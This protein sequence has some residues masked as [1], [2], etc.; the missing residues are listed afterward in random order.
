MSTVLHSYYLILRSFSKCLRRITEPLWRL[1]FWAFQLGRCD[2]T[3]PLPPSP[4]AVKRK[5]TPPNEARN[6]HRPNLDGKIFLQLPN[7]YL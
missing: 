3:R 7:S 1:T 2:V 4:R 6:A 5:K